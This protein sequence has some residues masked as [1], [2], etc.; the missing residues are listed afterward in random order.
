VIGRPAILVPLPGALDQDQ[1]NN[2][3]VLAEA[4]AGWLVPQAELTPGDLADRLTG[5]LCTPTQLA[6]MAEAARAQGRADA[7]KRLAE[8]VES[9]AS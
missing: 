4:G 8:L 3:K 6:P 5:L 2:A 1:A 9:V 7:V